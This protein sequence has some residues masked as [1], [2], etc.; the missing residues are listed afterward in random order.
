MGGPALQVAD[1]SRH[2]CPKALFPAR[3][4]P[5]AS[6]HCYEHDGGEKSVREDGRKRTQ[7]TQKK[8]IF[9]HL[10]PFGSDDGTARRASNFSLAGHILPPLLRSL[11]SFAA[12]HLLVDFAKPLWNQ[13]EFHAVWHPPTFWRRSLRGGP[14]IFTDVTSTS[15]KE[16][17]RYPPSSH[18]S[19]H[20][21]SVITN[22]V[23]GIRARSNRGNSS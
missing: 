21:R 20:S 15:P 16:P 18:S 12:I 4:S 8:R 3:G 11:R 6:P 22:D 23:C 19:R 5:G 9:G 13:A 7:K 1:P 14:N 2:H 10:P 17:I